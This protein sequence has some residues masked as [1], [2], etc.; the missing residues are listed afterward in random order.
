MNASAYQTTQEIIDAI[1]SVAPH[2]DS[3]SSGIAGNVIEDF[4]KIPAHV[5]ERDGWNEIKD[6]L[7]MGCNYLI[8][9]ASDEAD[10]ADEWWND[11]CNGESLVDFRNLQAIIDRIEPSDEKHRQ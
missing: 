2:I 7:Y 10:D 1:E 11:W 3:Q 9:A 6:A 8:C 4:L 5:Y